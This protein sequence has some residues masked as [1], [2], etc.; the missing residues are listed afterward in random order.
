MVVGVI[1]AGGYGKR[2]KPLTEMVPKPLVEIKDNYTIL[3]RQ[4]LSLKYAGINEVYLLVGYLWEKIKDRYGD[5]WNNLQIHYLV[6]NK[7]QGTLYA[8]SNCFSMLSEDSVVMNGDVVSDFNIKKMIKRGEENKD[9]LL[10]IAVT[11]MR[12]PYGIIEFRDDLILSFREKPILD[13]YINAGLY[14]VKKEAYPYFQMEYRDRAVER[15]V[16]PR[17]AEMRRAFVYR[18]DD[19]FWQSV[20]S[21]KDLEKVRK[22]YENREDTPWGY[23]KEKALFEGKEGIELYIKKGYVPCEFCADKDS[24]L[25]VS[26]GEGKLSDNSDSIPLEKGKRIFINKGYCGKIIASENLR[27]YLIPK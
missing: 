21:L 13:H 7:P 15:T 12:S 22:E 14:Y 5:S 27:V 24:Y 26:D 11:K 23:R 6:E 18:E 25:V 2:L 9:A 20:D 19:I 1:L 17:I 3:D 16:F 8:L 10:L 4:L